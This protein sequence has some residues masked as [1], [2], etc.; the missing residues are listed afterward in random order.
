M[1]GGARTGR[2][3]LD[4]RRTSTDRPAPHV[5]DARRGGFVLAVVIFML[6]AISVA[7]MTGYLLV[8]SEHELSRYS[9]QGAEALTV[10]RAGLERFV[11]EQ[12]GAV[13]D[14]V[15]YALGEGVAVVTPRRL[16]TRDPRTDVY[17]VRSEGTVEDIRLPATP[18]RRVVGAYAVHH[19]RPLTPYATAMIGADD[20]HVSGTGEVHGWDHN[21][22][23]DCAVGGAPTLPGVLARL[24]VTMGSADDIDGDPDFLLWSGGASEIADSL[25][26]RWDVLTDPNFAVDAVNSLPDFG[27]IPADSFPVV[28]YTGW[29]TASFTGRGLLIIDGVFDPTTSFNWDGIVVAGEIDEIVQ[30]YIDGILVAGMDGPNSYS[31]IDFQMDVNYHSCLVEAAN[32]S[33]SYMELLHHTIAELE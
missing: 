23:A 32:E 17:W 13:P 15:T 10:A 6:F 22:S 30:G 2:G 20:V 9:G 26:L 27:A 4:R 28:R 12:I 16:F 7:G 21:T 19:R 33:L 18:A 3:A 31:S 24:G 25:D 8:S 11:A 1:R 14:T 5:T 29:V